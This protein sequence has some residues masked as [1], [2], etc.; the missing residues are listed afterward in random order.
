MMM[1]RRTFL[2]IAAGTLFAPITARADDP[3]HF[4]SITYN[5]LAFRGYPDDDNTR[6]AIQIRREQHP[7]L[8]ARALAEYKPDI[9]TLQEGPPEALVAR[10][11]KELGMNYVW[12]PGGW[13][14]ND[15]Y[16]G[17]F[18]GAVIT[19]FPIIES[20]N[21]PSAGDPH[22]EALFTRHL[23]R[24]VLDT[25]AGKLHVITTHLHAQSARAREREIAEIDKLARQLRETAPVLIQGDMNHRETSDE[26]ALWKPAGLVDANAALN[27]TEI[28]T[29][30]SVQP[31]I[32][33]D[34]FFTHKDDPLRPVEGHVLNTGAFIIH[35]DDPASYA[36]SDHIPVM[37]DFEMTPRS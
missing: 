1:R 27:L 19:R 20:E 13:E 33:I 22:P 10:F 31:R 35:P 7:E 24:A 16:P 11:A 26:Y 15:E 4:R 25:P 32:H 6:V 14:G 21:R 34:R 28:G 17:G 23:G 37:I 8:T 12:F 3:F 30:S 2:G 9:I 5:V 36:L 29:F 18:P